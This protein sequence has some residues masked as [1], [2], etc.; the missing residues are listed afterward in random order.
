MKLPLPHLALV[1]LSVWSGPSFGFDIFDYQGASAK[2]YGGAGIT[3]SRNGEAI[4][5]N[6][7]NLC[8]TKG[9]EYHFD[10]SP[11]SL[12]YQFTPAE[13]SVPQGNID[14]PL[15]PLLSAGGAMRAKG[16]PLAVG[17]IFVPTGANT[18]TEVKDFPIAVGGQYQV[19]ALENTRKGY[20]LGFGV[21]YKPLKNLQLGASLI[22]DY[23]D[24][25]S[26]I[27]LAGQEFL[28][29]SNQNRI[30]LPRLGV[31]YRFKGLG[32]LGVEW[33]PSVKSWYSLSANVSGADPVAVYRQTYRPQVYGI[34]VRSEFSG[35]NQVF[36]QY[37]FEDWVNGTF[38]EQ[39]P[40]QTILG[41]APVEF[42]NAHSFVLGAERRMKS[43][44]KAVGSFSFFGPNKG[45]GVYD[46]SGNIAFNGRGVQDFESL[47][48]YHVTTGL[49]RAFRGDL[50]SIYGSYIRATAV[51][52]E[53]TPS[54][55]FY[56][57][58][59]YMLGYGHRFR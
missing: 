53:D 40:T 46:E 52:D 30:L 21:G 39:N 55:G 31:N 58:T 16:S 59:I 35:R 18:K 26:K 14:V 5:Y 44:G 2:L 29:V 56:E 22:Y 41:D 49:E 51:S 23:F 9:S 19:A 43:L 47:K 1:F 11:S 54:A 32:K 27:F 4:F 37:R 50:A 42:L 8:D 7:A 6:P 33:Q 15:L 12:S 17:L 10:L 38:A 45:G 20:K 3:E 36:G 28:A 34:G 24:S 25:E 48:R 13:P 57:M